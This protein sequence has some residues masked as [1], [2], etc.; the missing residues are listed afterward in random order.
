MG[1]FSDPKWLINLPVST[2]NVISL[3]NHYSNNYLIRIYLLVSQSG[4][5]LNDITLFN[6]RFPT[7]L[8][9]IDIL[10]I[11]YS[12]VH[13]L[14]LLFPHNLLLLPKFIT[15]SADVTLD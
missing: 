11:I 8:F 12:P 14:I 3:L 9:K 6:G 13:H 5:T 2:A 1:V 4:Y 15:I 7:D 10:N